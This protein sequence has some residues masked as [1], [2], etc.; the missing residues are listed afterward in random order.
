MLHQARGSHALRYFAL[1]GQ[2]VLNYVCVFVSILLL[3]L[4]L[5]EHARPLLFVILELGLQEGQIG[6]DFADGYEARFYYKID[7]T[8]LA[9]CHVRGRSVVELADGELVLLLQVTL[10][11]ELYE[12]EIGPQ[13]AQ[14]PWFGRVGDV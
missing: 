13:A 10:L 3:C 5:V 6:E 11:K 1:A 9:L 8:D 2:I 7:E 4:V 12:D 14:M